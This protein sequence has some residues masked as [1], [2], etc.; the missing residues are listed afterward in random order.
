MRIITVGI[1]DYG[2]GNH[3]SIKN[4]IHNIGFRSRRVQGVTDIE[5]VDLLLLPGVGAFSSAMEQLN[6]KGL[7]ELIKQWVGENKPL[8]GICL[9]MQL[10]ANVSYEH[11]VTPGLNLIPGNVKAL[12]DPGWHI[13][14]NKLVLTQESPEFLKTS[15][16][17]DFYFNHSYEFITS[18]EYVIASCQLKKSI[19]AIVK[20]K[21]VCGM[22][23]HPEKSQGAGERLLLSTVE[24][25]VNA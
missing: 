17:K 2:A 10:L 15:D 8:L 9:G 16:S 4:R 13:G 21:R 22:Q 23:F 25:L 20:Y 18:D 11:G 14:W 19:T 3:S 6:C 7:T 12:G 5:G 24:E 1:I